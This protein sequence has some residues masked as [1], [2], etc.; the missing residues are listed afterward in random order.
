MN[1]FIDLGN[2]IFQAH[3]AMDI[4]MDHIDDGATVLHVRDDVATLVLADDSYTE[5]NLAPIQH[6]LNA[7]RSMT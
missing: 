6:L 2:D 7:L 4:L 5:I 1:G 3:C